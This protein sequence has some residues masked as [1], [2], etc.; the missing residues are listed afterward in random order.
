MT[1]AHT[2][3]YATASAIVASLALSTIAIAVMGRGIA[4]L[5]LSQR[6]LARAQLEEQLESAAAE[7]VLA[8]VQSKS[9]GPYSWTIQGGAA[10]GIHV[11]A[12]PEWRKLSPDAAASV[13]EADLQ[14][15]GAAAPQTVRAQLT[16]TN[17]A[18]PPNPWRIADADS[19]PRWRRCG[20][21]NVSTF[22]AAAK[23]LPAPPEV[24]LANGQNFR[25]GEVWRLV[26]RSPTGWADERFVRF[27]GAAP[28]LV[29]VIDRRLERDP[30]GGVL[31][32]SIAKAQP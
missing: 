8:I 9:A 7:A 17:P 23:L 16:R 12:E 20:P 15:L 13:S 14:L 32:P 27:T 19:S 5:K 1:K 3:G 26:L 18:Q 4:A 25:L 2:D 28:N 30:T 10:S 22:G 29:A 24:P 6:E 11:D 31:C 21:S